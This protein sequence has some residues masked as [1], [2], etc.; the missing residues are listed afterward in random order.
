MEA[1]WGK[2]LTRVGHNRSLAKHQIE[3]TQ[4]LMGELLQ[5]VVAVAVFFFL[6]LN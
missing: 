1:V 4:P 5:F 2:E 6:V 3:R